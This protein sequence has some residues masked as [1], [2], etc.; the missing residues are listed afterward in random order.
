MSN[1]IAGNARAINFD[2][3][4]SQIKDM[5]NSSETIYLG[6]DATQPSASSAGFLKKLFNLFTLTDE[7]FNNDRNTF[8]EGIKQKYGEGLYAM[9]KSTAEAS[10]KYGISAATANKIISTCEVL[11]SVGKE[12]DAIKRNFGGKIGLVCSEFVM[13]KLANH[14]SA[15]VEPAAITG[16]KNGI[17]ELVQ[18]LEGKD[19]SKGDAVILGKALASVV[20]PSDAAEVM[21]KVAGDSRHECRKHC[22]LPNLLRGCL[23]LFDTVN[24]SNKKDPIP[25]AKGMAVL[26]KL[27][28]SLNRLVKNG[29]LSLPAVARTLLVKTGKM[30]EKDLK[31]SYMGNFTDAQSPSKR[32]VFLYDHMGLTGLGVE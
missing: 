30:S 15:F 29:T 19:I 18:L 7:R 9:A 26:G 22:K 16:L 8:L 31:S 20:V 27:A 11:Q 24:D 12:L 10:G 32:A 25:Y 21:V 17:V 6:G 3:M 4:F 5:G 1:A 2:T 13:A 28:P 23:V 14:G